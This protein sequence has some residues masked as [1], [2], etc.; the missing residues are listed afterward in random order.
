M[1]HLSLQF[2]MRFQWLSILNFH[3]D[4]FEFYQKKGQKTYSILYNGFSF[5]SSILISCIPNGIFL[6]VYNKVYYKMDIY[7]FSSS[8]ISCIPNGIGTKPLFENKANHKNVCY[9]MSEIGLCDVYE[10]ANV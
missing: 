3:L 10:P 4:V 9:F 6:M 5:F 1:K 7:F 8:L 2:N